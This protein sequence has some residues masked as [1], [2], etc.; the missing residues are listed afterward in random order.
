MSSYSAEL[1]V[2]RV[3]TVEAI[4]MRYI[5]GSLGVPMKGPTVLCG[6]NLGIIL[7]ITKPDSGFKKKHVEIAYHKFWEGRAAGI[8]NPIKVCTMVIQSKIFK[9]STSVG[10]MGDFSDA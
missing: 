6:E 7:L 9:N 1:C 3:A 10:K 2:S 4:D 8:V 5:L